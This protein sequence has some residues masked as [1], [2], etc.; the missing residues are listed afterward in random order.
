MTHNEKAQSKKV[1]II[2]AVVVVML[3]LVLLVLAGGGQEG[4]VTKDVNQP[5][6]QS[7]SALS[8][9]SSGQPKDKTKDIVQ[10]DAEEVCQDANFL[11]SYISLDDTSIVTFSYKPS[12]TDMGD[13]I[14]VLQ[15][16]GEDRGADRSI[17]F[18]CDVV[19][20]GDKTTVKQLAID[21]DVV[22]ER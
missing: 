1:L 7:E 5:D 22:F 20:D 8:N 19:K 18:V 2:T 17:L 21:G 9:K 10:S 13:G 11:Q 14:K 3:A 16:S 15:W 6:E 4:G 12:F